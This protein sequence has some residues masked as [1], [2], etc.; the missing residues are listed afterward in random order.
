[1]STELIASCPC[2]ESTV[3]LLS[4]IIVHKMTRSL[5]LQLLGSFVGL[6]LDLALDRESVWPIDTPKPIRETWLLVVAPLARSLAT[7]DLR[8]CEA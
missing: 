4:C 8:L 7:R 3:K 6:D 5:S 1:M 2:F